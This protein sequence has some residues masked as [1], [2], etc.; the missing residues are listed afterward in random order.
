M[1]ARRTPQRLVA[2]TAIVVAAAGMPVLTAPAPASAAPAT[3]TYLCTFPELGDVDV[4]L[5]VNVSNLPVELPV[6]VPVAAGLWNVVAT[7]HLDDLT[8]AYLVGHTNAIRAEVD[9]L[10]PLLGDKAVPIAIASAT[11]ALPV[12]DPLDVPMTGTN[13]EFT[14]KFWA[15]DLPL[16]LP[17]AFTL[18]LA[19]GAGAPLFSVDCEWG[20]GDLGVIGTIDVV[21]QSATMTRKLLK[22]PVKTTKRAKVLVTVLTQTGASAPGQVIAALGA[23]NLA[24][25]ELVDG[26]VKL[27]LPKLAAGKHRVTLTYLGSKFVDKTVR[28]VTVKVVRPPTRTS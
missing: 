28:N 9:A 3:T 18:D 6:A 13:A 2:A 15:D 12:A 23:R 16:E 7:L 27:R 21:K 25:G 26:R 22:K 8:T 20:D 14:P 10:G 24:V 5:T 19:D 17:E 4:P 1:S 11:E